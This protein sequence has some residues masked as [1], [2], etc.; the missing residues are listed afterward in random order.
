MRK[1]MEKYYGK[2]S[3]VGKNIK[4]AVKN[5][6]DE[7]KDSPQTKAVV[8]AAKS[9]SVQ[10][11]AGFLIPGGAAL[12]APKIVKAV[13]AAGKAIKKVVGAEKKKSLAKSYDP[14]IPFKPDYKPPKTDILERRY[15][16]DYLTPTKDR[17][18][19]RQEASD[20]YKKRMKE[21][22]D[23]LEKEIQSIRRDPRLSEHQRINAVDKLIRSKK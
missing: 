19:R 17:E 23:K 14:S 2:P 10:T 9:P 1:Q 12:K 3:E 5:K 18:I 13:K 7:M 22:Q 11:A 20:F 8:K 6:I 16:K 21:N 15:E 4:K